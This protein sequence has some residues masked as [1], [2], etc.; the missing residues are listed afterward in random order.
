MAEI[1]DM[2]SDFLDVLVSIEVLTSEQFHF[3][4]GKNTKTDQV[5]QL[6]E[7]ITGESL[8]DEKR[9]LFLNVVDQTQ[10][11]YVSNFIQGNGHRVA[12]HGDHWPLHE[13][14]TE[15]NRM[16]EN[17]S[18]LSDLVDSRNGLLDEMFAAGCINSR[19]KH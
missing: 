3:V 18:R 16:R 19:Q 6:L 2:C 10:Q 4:Q 7:E 8:S 15:V 12:E 1:L 17:R 13:C 9:K 14:F 11:K 5:R